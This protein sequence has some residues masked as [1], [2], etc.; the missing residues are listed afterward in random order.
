MKLKLAATSVVIA[1]ALTSMTVHAADSDTDRNNPA[2]FVKDSAITTNI[3]TKL[4]TENLGSMKHIKVDTDK[5]GIVW[6]SGTANR[7]QH[8]RSKVG[9]E[10][11][12]GA[13]GQIAR[14][15]TRP[16][17]AGERVRARESRE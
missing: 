8:R 2:T 11:H 10:R 9:E 6:M 12:H 15:R 13:E 5:D 4:A 3:K 7:Q 1:F 16:D 17:H 14:P